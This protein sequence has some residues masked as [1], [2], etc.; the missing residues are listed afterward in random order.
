MRISVAK[1]GVFIYTGNTKPSARGGFVF[2]VVVV[3]TCG[4]NR[5]AGKTT[6]A[7][8]EVF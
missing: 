7:V 2:F 1:R 6:K 3:Q 8:K 4:I 5:T